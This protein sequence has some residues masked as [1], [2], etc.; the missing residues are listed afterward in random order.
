MILAISGMDVN[1]ACSSRTRLYMHMPQSVLDSA[2]SVEK[3]WDNRGSTAEIT[4]IV[5]KPLKTW[6]MGTNLMKQ[7]LLHLLAVISLVGLLH[8]YSSNAPSYIGFMWSLKKIKSSLKNISMFSQRSSEQH[9]QRIGP[10]PESSVCSFRPFDVT[11]KMGGYPN[12]HPP[13]AIC[14]VRAITDRNISEFL[15]CIGQQGVVK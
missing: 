7:Q 9:Y 2:T 12:F 6:K 5:K 1:A 8:S 4:A 13:Y 3:H 11:V 15:V 10:W 14:F